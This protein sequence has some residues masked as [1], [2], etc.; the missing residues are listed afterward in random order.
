MRTFAG[1]KQESVEEIKAALLSRCR[2]YKGEEKCPN[3]VNF[4][5]WECEERF[6]HFMISGHYEPLNAAV[7]FFRSVG[8]DKEPALQDGTPIEV[9][10]LLFNRF[11]YQSEVDPIELAKPFVRRY[12]KTFAKS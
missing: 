3:G 5:G 10:A 9:Q 2:F 8:L 12:V 1:M 4:F 6:V 11:C 7:S